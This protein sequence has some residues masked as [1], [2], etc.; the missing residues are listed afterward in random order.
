MLS[1]HPYSSLDGTI[2][3]LSHLARVY[4][5]LQVPSAEHAVIQD[6]AIH[7]LRHAPV[8]GDQEDLGIQQMGRAEFRF[9]KRP[10]S[11]QQD[12]MSTP[13][14]ECTNSC[15]EPSG[16][17]CRDTCQGCAPGIAFIPPYIRVVTWEGSG[18]PQV[19]KSFWTGCPV[20]TAESVGTS[21]GCG[22]A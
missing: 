6:L 1:P 2:V 16:R 22:G 7:L 19:E 8:L 5:T 17:N 12:L 21:D 18:F 13:P 11:T 14:Q 15:V 10:V 4:S 3:P 9:M 20:V